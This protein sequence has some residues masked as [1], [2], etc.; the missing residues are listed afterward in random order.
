MFVTDLL[1]TSEDITYI[2]LSAKQIAVIGGRRK[3]GEMAEKGK[4]NI[5]PTFL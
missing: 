1:N 5:L 3:T 4:G 2:H